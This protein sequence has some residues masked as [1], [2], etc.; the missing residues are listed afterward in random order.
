[1][2]NA[3][4]TLK[5]AFN[6]L[7]L[8]SGLWFCSTSSYADDDI[9]L[10]S[11]IIRQ[12]NLPQGWV[13]INTR[14]LLVTARTRIRNLAVGSDNPSALQAGRPVQFSANREHELLTI[15]VYP[16]D[17]EQRARLGDTSV[18]TLQ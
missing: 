16:I 11:G 17:P 5:H 2:L 12:V 15:R 14:R 8:I 18:E 4:S 10:Q 9:P 3:N 1:M 6:T 7:L 13:V